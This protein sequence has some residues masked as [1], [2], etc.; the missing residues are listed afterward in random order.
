MQR[1]LF[2]V[3]AAL[4]ATTSVARAATYNAD[5]P[6]KVRAG[7]IKATLLDLVVAGKRLVAVGERGHVLLS[8]DEGKTWRQAKAVPTR[9]TLTCVH[10]T[11]ANTLWAA[12]HGGMILRSAD[13]G[14]TWAIVTGSAGY[15]LMTW[16]DI[17]IHMPCDA[18]R[19]TEWAGLG[20]EIAHV[21]A[22]T[23]LPTYDIFD[24][25]R[26]FQP[27]AER[28]VFR[29]R[30]RT[31]GIAICEDLW[32]GAFWGPRRPYPIDPVE[33]LV[34]QGA[35]QVDDRGAQRGI[36]HRHRLVGHQH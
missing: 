23:L 17:D 2:T 16:R 21:Q 33:E 15:D 9:T 35:K 29:F 13:A 27:A 30:E 7:A 28:R 3:A 8:D 25:S 11:D 20:G 34:A 24:E 12:G 4:C 32:S 14:E 22:K 36:D 31:I 1:R 19:W 26:Y 6:A 10:A 18:D 5:G